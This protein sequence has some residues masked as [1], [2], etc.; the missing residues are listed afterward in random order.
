MLSICR[1]S[2]RCPAAN[3]DAIIASMSLVDRIARIRIEVN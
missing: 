3:E 2:T 1:E